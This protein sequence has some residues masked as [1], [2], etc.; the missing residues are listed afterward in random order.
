M[1]QR[2]VLKYFKRK[3]NQEDE[4]SELCPPEPKK[5]ARSSDDHV[6]PEYIMRK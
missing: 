1:A 4:P 5:N 6:G 3:N 2:S